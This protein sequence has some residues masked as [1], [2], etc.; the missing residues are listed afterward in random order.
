[1]KKRNIFPYLLVIPGLVVLL[2]IIFLPFIRNVLYSFTD[3]KLTNPDYDIIGL[4]NYIDVFKKG[5]LTEALKHS[6]VWVVL[7]I[8]L[9]MLLG[10]LAAFLQN[11][12]HIKGTFIFQIFLLLPWVLPEAVTGYIWKL[13]LNYE[14]GVYY[15]LLQFLHIIPEKYDIFANDFPAM[16]ACVMANVWR[17]FPIIAMTVLAKLRGIQVDQV[18]AAVL[19]GAN[20]RDI[21]RYIEIPHIKPVLMSVGTLCFVWTFNSFGIIDVMTGGGPAKATETLPVFLQR[22]AFQ[23]YD[24]SGAATYAVV[25][26][27]I[28]VTIVLCAMFLPKL[29]GKGD[30]E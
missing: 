9:M 4:K 6:L 27:V 25:G 8:V 22:E 19:D 16:F 26:L 18:E 3:Y 20:R 21:L 10:V 28:L 13:L 14:T 2:A 17:S 15:Q 23:F 24:Y 11:S 29:L 1:M 12:K 30:N 7:N 5:D